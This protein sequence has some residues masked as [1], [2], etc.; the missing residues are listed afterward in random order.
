MRD[1][2]MRTGQ[3]F[4]LTYSITSRPSFEETNQFR[5]HI[6]RVKDS[7]KVPMVLVGNK[8]DEEAKREVPRQE[9]EKK[10]ETYGVPFFE[11]R[12]VASR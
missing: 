12:Y 10:S 8:C 7:D 2:Y 9:G 5:E 4:I 11:T 3:G 6:L 1:Q